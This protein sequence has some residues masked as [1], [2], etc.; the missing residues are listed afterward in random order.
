MLTIEMAVVFVNRAC[1]ALAAVAAEKVPP[2]VLPAAI[3]VAG[4]ISVEPSVM[5][6]TD[7][8]R[9]CD[10]TLVYNRA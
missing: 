8:D 10:V 2:L 6:F 5:L 3:A 1:S 4:R 9:I 7:Q